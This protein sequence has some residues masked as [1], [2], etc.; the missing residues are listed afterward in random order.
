ML[1]M[2]ATLT[3]YRP[4]KQAFTAFTNIQYIGL[5]RGI[6]NVSVIFSKIGF[7]YVYMSAVLP[8]TRIESNKQLQL[9][10]TREHHARRNCFKL[11]YVQFQAVWSCAS[12]Q[13]NLVLNVIS[14]HWN[15]YFR[16]AALSMIIFYYEQ[17][18]S[19]I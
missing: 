5:K 11:W 13:K 1:F 2:L 18:Y 9:V 19:N 12:N 3:C 10:Q 8:F 17:K 4:S 6:T 16:I 14:V 7:L 15:D